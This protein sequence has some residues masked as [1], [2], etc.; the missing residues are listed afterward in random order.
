MYLTANEYLDRFGTIE[1]IR[2]T[3]EARTG[4]YDS[5]KLEEG[6]SDAEEEVDSYLG[7]RYT[8]PL[9]SPPNIVK[10]FVAILARVNLH[11]RAGM[12]LSQA[13][14]KDAERVRQQLRDIAR[15]VMVLP[16]AT[17]PVEP[18]G[19]IADSA[20][21]GEYTGPTFSDDNLAGFDVPSSAGVSRWRL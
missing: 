14:E 3:D 10:G 4:A 20:S 15:G 7:K 1:T 13:L 18:I 17:G 12:T 21:S 11:H 16:T 2:L 8:T 6:I 5:A 19:G 9:S